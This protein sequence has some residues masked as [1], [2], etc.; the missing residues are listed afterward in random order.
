MLEAFPELGSDFLVDEVLGFFTSDVLGW[1]AAGDHDAV[2][3][4]FEYLEWLHEHGPPA[5]AA[6]CRHSLLRSDR[7]WPSEA[8]DW[9]GPRTRSALRDESGSARIDR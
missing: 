3:R 2:R 1:A 4:S 8:C 6:Q 5:W 9:V 7:V